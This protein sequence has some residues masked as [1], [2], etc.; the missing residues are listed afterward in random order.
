MTGPV[1]IVLENYGGRILTYGLAVRE[2]IGK[3]GSEWSE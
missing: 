3:L 1:Q 2:F